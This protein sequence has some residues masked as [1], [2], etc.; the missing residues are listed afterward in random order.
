[1]KQENVFP[2]TVL[3][4]VIMDAKRT[5]DENKELIRPLLEAE[6]LVASGWDVKMSGKGRYMSI[7]FFADIPSKEVLTRLYNQL[8]E[9]DEVRFVL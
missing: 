7:N 6:N 2:A 4:K 3:T 5:Y 1:M 8:Q 9:I